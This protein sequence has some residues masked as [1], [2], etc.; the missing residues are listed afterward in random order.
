MIVASR[1]LSYWTSRRKGSMFTVRK[2][3][4]ALYTGEEEESSR[5]AES[6]NPTPDIAFPPTRA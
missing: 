2:S 5:I 4:R 1:Y 3:Q 6:R